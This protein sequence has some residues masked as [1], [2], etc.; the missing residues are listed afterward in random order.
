MQLQIILVGPHQC[1][2]HVHA[3]L[4]CLHVV[5]VY[6]V[7]V[8]HVYCVHV[9]HVYCLHVVPLLSS[10]PAGGWKICSKSIGEQNSI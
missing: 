3:P 10:S 4:H 6:C 5:H 8:V 9:V 7:H 2:I 1:S